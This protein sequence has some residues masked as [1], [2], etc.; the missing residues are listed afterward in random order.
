LLSEFDLSGQVAIVTGGN[1]GKIIN[2]AAEYSLFGS[3]RV[4]S[5]SASKGGV[6]QLTRSL[7][8]AWAVDNIQVNAILP[9]WIRTNMT[10]GVIND[11]AFS[12]KIIDRTPANRFG[13]PEE[14][15]GAA[16]FLASRAAGFVTGQT[17]A[18][19]GGFSIA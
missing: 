10:Q 3:P 2:I 4:V 5:Y 6:I 11:T 19:D 14:L 1:G 18:V 8:V 15:A 13:E 16:V 17:L 12:G 7:A 9:G